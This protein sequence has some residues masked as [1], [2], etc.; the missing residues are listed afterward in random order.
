MFD[1]L[2]DEHAVLH[3]ALDLLGHRALLG[4]LV[5]SPLGRKHDVDAGALAGEE[6]GGQALLAQV[7]GGPVD[8]FEDDGRDDAVDLQRELGRV[9]DLEA[10]DE[11]VDDDGE[12]AAVFDG[13]GVGLVRDLDDGLVAA[14]DQDGLILLRGDL[15]NLSDV[16]EVLDVPLVGLELPSRWFLHAHALWLGRLLAGHWRLGTSGRHRRSAAAIGNRR[17]GTETRVLVRHLRFVDLA[18]VRSNSLSS[19]VYLRKDCRHVTG[20]GRSTWSGGSWWRWWRRWWWWP[21]GRRRSARRTRTGLYLSEGL[22]GIDAVLI[23]SQT[24]RIVLPEVCDK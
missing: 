14:G 15:D 10:A 24:L 3:V 4:V 17:A 22:E 12:A 20:L 23:P 7:D 6:L 18:E 11:G 5:R 8:L 13:D 16:V 19:L 9:D 2:A 1:D 21:R